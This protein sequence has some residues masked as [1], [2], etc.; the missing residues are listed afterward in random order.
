[1]S[2]KMQTIFRTLNPGA[3]YTIVANVLCKNTTLSMACK[4]FLLTVL[5]LPNDW[6]FK[7]EWLLNSFNIG[8]NETYDLLNEAIAAG[9]CCRISLR[10][11]KGHLTGHLEYVF[12]SDP[13]LLEDRFPTRRE[14]G[15]RY[16]DIP[17]SGKS[18]RILSKNKTTNYSHSAREGEL[19]LAKPEDEPVTLRDGVLE[20]H[21]A[22]RERYLAE[23]GGDE[24]LLK[25][26]LE[27]VAGSLQTNSSH[28][29]LVQ[30]RRQMARILERRHDHRKRDE[31]RDAA[32]RKD[33]EQRPKQFESA[34]ERRRREAG[35]VIEGLARGEL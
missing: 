18:V 32:W 13:K 27:Q 7:P 33:R 10:N 9:F 3:E 34:M 11:E 25:T 6:K 14:I 8:R 15:D 23:A 5:S 29:L 1:M 26:L 24:W 22:E 19:D 30:F 17:I 31:A 20:L 16:T 12:A 35:A 4:G 2:N 21:G 28:S